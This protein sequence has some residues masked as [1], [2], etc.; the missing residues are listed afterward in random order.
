[1]MINPADIC[2]LEPLIK[3]EN[4]HPHEATVELTNEFGFSPHALFILKERFLRQNE[5]GET[6]ETPS[7]MFQR[8]TNA[9][10]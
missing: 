3:K 5:E 8:V 9:V 1:M 2:Q 7:G 6:I 10:N 4:H